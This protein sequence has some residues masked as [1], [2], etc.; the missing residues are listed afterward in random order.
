M[1][2]LDAGAEG[3][4]AAWAAPAPDVELLTSAASAALKVTASLEASAFLR[5]TTCM[6][7][8][9]SSLLGRSSFSIK[10]LACNNLAELAARR[11]SELLLGSAKIVV[12]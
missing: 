5:Y 2:G 4:C 9:A 7:P 11:M 1:E 8:A 3:A 12:L 6:L 10:S